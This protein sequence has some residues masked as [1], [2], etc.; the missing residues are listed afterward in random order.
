MSIERRINSL[1]GSSHEPGDAESFLTNL[2][3]EIIQR[4]RRRQ[5]IIN[6]V[7]GL[8]VALAMGVG[9]Y[10]NNPAA[11]ST[12]STVDMSEIIIDLSDQPDSITVFDDEEFIVASMD[13]LI[14]G[15]ELISTGWSIIEDLSLYSYLET[16]EK[17]SQEERS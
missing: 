8:V 10:I 2:K 12:F 7:S 17:I 5:N 3:G 11:D 4:D 9:I 1:K 13:Y 15:T 6:S 14:G 16:G